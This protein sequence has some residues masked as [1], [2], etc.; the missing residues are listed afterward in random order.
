MFRKGKNSEKRQEIDTQ[1]EVRTY[2][3]G[4]SVL[5]IAKAYRIGTSGRERK[6]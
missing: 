2:P 1:F 6:R 5:Q 4:L 3:F